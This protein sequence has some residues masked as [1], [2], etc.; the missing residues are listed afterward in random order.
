MKIDFYE[1]FPTREN[2]K[3]IKLI[4]FNSKLFI[5]TKSLKKFKKIEKQI[6]KINKKWSV[7]TGQ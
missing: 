7:R 3:K 5:A 4:N 6:K 2:L 1:E